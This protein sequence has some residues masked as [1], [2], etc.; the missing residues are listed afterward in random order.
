MINLYKIN[1]SILIKLLNG[2]PLPKL[3]GSFFKLL[4]CTINN[5]LILDQTNTIT[6]MTIIDIMT[7][8]IDRHY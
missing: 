1:G 7:I 4:I 3:L 8:E 2:A 6:I 5:N